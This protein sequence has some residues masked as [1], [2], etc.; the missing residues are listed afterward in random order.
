MIQINDTYLLLMLQSWYLHDLSEQFFLLSVLLLFEYTLYNC[1]IDIIL[2]L[3]LT[4]PITYGIRSRISSYHAILIE[5]HEDFWGEL[6][7]VSIGG[8]KY[9]LQKL[10]LLSVYCLVSSL[11]SVVITWWLLLLRS[12]GARL[13]DYIRCAK[14]WFGNLQLSRLRLICRRGR[15][16]HHVGL[17]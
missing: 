1:L 16:R 17:L 4:S 9:L 15:T 11:L 14:R 13:V 2:E 12:L 10:L 6:T 3:F 7:Q 5:H 8:P